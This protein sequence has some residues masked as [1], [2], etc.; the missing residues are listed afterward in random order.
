MFWPTSSLL[1]YYDPLIASLTAVSDAIMEIERGLGEQSQQSPLTVHIPTLYGGSH[2]PDL[3]SVADQA[4]LTEAETIEAH[5]GT[6]YLVVHAGVQPRIPVSRRPAGGP[7]DPETGN[8]AHGDPG[9]V[10]GHRR[11][12]DG[13]LSGRESR[14]V[15][16][17]SRTPLKLFDARN[18]PPSL[19]KA[20]DYVRFVPIPGERE[21]EKLDE[22][23]NAGEYEATREARP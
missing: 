17:H 9:R 18:D 5:S 8:P 12:T 7:G 3:R 1:V 19:L 20:G 23:I 6:D 15:A 13:R 10:G 2:G 11:E 16:A 22:L 4:G 21:F 14:R